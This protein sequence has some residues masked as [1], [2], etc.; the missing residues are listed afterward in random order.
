MC[1]QNNEGTLNLYKK[2][3]Y[4]I[5]SVSNLVRECFHDKVLYLSC[6]K[7]DRIL[8]YV[9]QLSQMRLKLKDRSDFLQK[10]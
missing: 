7:R 2:R 1:F 9:N 10:P 3:K 4:C 6:K 8:N 5:F